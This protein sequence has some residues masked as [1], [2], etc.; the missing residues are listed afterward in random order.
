MIDPEDMKKY[1]ALEAEAGALKEKMILHATKIAE[2]LHGKGAKVTNFGKRTDDGSPY[3][4]GELSED[5][6]FTIRAEYLF[7]ADWE[8]KVAEYHRKVEL[9]HQKLLEHW[10]KEKKQQEE[11]K[12][13]KELERL[14]KKYPDMV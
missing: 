4:Y 14:K 3:A 13:L 12:D 11:N 6:A 10:A 5:E 2:A 8:A 1:F 7:A 9:R